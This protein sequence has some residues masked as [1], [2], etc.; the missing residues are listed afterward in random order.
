MQRSRQIRWTVLALVVALTA[1]GSA[2]APGGAAP[3]INLSVWGGFPEIVPVYQRAAADYDRAHPN[4]HTTV[5]AT[6]LRDYER[7]LAASLPSDT[8]GDIL[9]VD[10]TTV[11][12][13]IDAGLIAKAPGDVAQ[14]VRGRSFGGAAQ[15]HATV[16]SDV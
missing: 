14:Y 3:T 12:R 6:Q 10:D 11:F 5:L 13:Y 16:G 15:Q 8:A 9:E 4:V 7:K 2:A 1:L